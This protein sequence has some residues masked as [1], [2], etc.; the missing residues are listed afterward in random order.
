MCSMN[1][2]AF[3]EKEKTVVLVNRAMYLPG[4]GGYKRTMYLYD[5]IRKMG[6]KPILLTSDFNHY[7]KEQRNVDEFRTNHPDYADIVFLHTRTYDKNISLQRRL[8]ENDWK[9]AVSQWVADHANS[10]DVVM[11]SMPDMN[12]ILSVS[13]VCKKHNISVVIDVRDLRPEAFKVLLKNELLYNVCTYPMK[14]KADKA[15]ACADKLFAVSEEYLQRGSVN[16]SHAK[17]KKAV[18]IGAVLEKFDN[19]IK[20]Y[21]H[22]IDKPE[23]ELWVTYAGT[24]GTSYDMVTVIDAVAKL[25]NERFDGKKEKYEHTI[26]KP[27]DELW[28]TYAGTL[29]T[30]YDMVTVIDAVAKLKNERFDGKKVQLIVLGQGPDK[31]AFV[32]HAE[33]IGATNIRFIGFVDYEKMAAYLSKSDMTINAIKR[34]GSQSIINKVAD[35]FAAGIPMLNGC[36][37]KE[38]QTMVEEFDVGLN[39]EPEDVDSLAR[40]IKKLANNSDLRQQMGINARKKEQQTMVEEFDVGLNYEPED[41]DSLARAIKKLANNSDLRQQMGINA[42]KLALEKFD[43]NKTY[44]EMIEE[45]YK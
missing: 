27:E 34:R 17:V 40:A 25:K 2:N 30:S 6:H 14:L 19:G 22:T 4:E 15:Y 5:M 23:D 11:M 18:Y 21:E 16:N 37:C 45:L 41:V 44:K 9:K 43:R 33:E 31:E 13:E 3:G 7:K 38:Q 42:R 32:K 10:I 28:V 20:K 1:L 12:T 8:A 36:V 24:L 35:Y 39:Y 29:G 26:D